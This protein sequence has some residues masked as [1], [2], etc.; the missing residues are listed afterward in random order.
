MSQAWALQRHVIFNS[1]FPSDALRANETVLPL[2]TSPRKQSGSVVHGDSVAA[3]QRRWSV[4]WHHVTDL[5]KLPDGLANR[6]DISSGDGFDAALCIILNPEREVPHATKKDDLI[7]WYTKQMYYHY[8]QSVK[9]ALDL[10]LSQRDDEAYFSDAINTLETAAQLY[11]LRAEPIFKGM[12]EIRAHEARMRFLREIHGLIASSQT[13]YFHEVM[14][15][16]LKCHTHAVLL[17]EDN[18]RLDDRVRFLALIDSLQ[19]IGLTDRR[20][21]VTF[22]EAMNEALKAHIEMA[23]NNIFTQQLD[24]GHVFGAN[25]TAWNNRKVVVS[26][27]ISTLYSWIED[28]FS[29]LAVEVMSKLGRP[30]TPSHVAAWKENALCI[31]AN[32]R[33]SQLYDI[34]LHWPDSR[35]G[36]LDL[37]SCV[38][39]TS[40]RSRLTSVFSRNL[41]RRLLHPGSSTLHILQVYISIIRTFHA[42][43]SSKVLLDRVVPSLQLYLCQRVDAIRIVVMGMLSNHQDV[44]TEASKGKL[45]ELAAI[46]NST[47]QAKRPALDDED[48]DW[49]DMDW[50]PA[51]IDAAANFKRPR[52][53]DIIGT[54]ISAL[55]SQE[56]FIKEF[57]VIVAERL[58]SVSSDLQQEVKVLNLLKRRYG[59]TA[60]QHCDVMLRD[61][62]ES[63][64]LDDLV[65]SAVKGTDQ[66]RDRCTLPKCSAKILSRLYWPNIEREHFLIPECVG[67]AQRQYS[68]NYRH[69]KSSRKLTWLDHVGTATVEL[70][71]ESCTVAVECKT[72]VATVIYAFGDES[73]DS[74][75][76]EDRRPIKLTVDDLEIKLQMDTDYIEEALAFWVK[77]K[78]LR[79]VSDG[80]YVVT[81]REEGSTG[82]QP[83]D[84]SVEDGGISDGSKKPSSAHSEKGPIY[85]QFIV[86]MLTN[87]PTAMPLP[88][89]T[90]MM[91]MLIPGGFAWTD[92]QFQEFMAEK[93]EA[94]EAELVGGK[95]R[96]VKK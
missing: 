14:V 35:G 79:Q 39:T 7:A 67:Q 22:A 83:V 30:I 13:E 69:I 9:P 56:M 88:R 43:D 63:K 49:N 44:G 16:L 19:S 78:V 89:M 31:L 52:S 77:H 26:Q 46:L 10:D 54:L 41:E 73:Q 70:E 65:T 95:Y 27:N 5:L 81:E 64:K 72:Y 59:D 48:Q 71:L 85:W 58:L 3:D 12:D 86:G 94:D 68:E 29:S 61:I 60:L 33:S 42:L 45:S 34:V 96:L 4:A 47:S 62:I 50:N 15:S 93:V 28:T 6:N 21:E 91:R 87:S 37:K 8:T 80:A 24:V 82:G 75:R 1:I 2:R 36:L 66:S 57:H 90:M 92:E 76:A 53:E 23:Y 74:Y 38:T 18:T 11:L 17:G 25:N 55:G 32:L 20:F 84:S 51:P 40:Q